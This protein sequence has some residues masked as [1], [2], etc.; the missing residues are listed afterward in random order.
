[1]DIRIRQCVLQLHAQVRARQRAGADKSAAT[2]APQHEPTW[3][4]AVAR[5]AARNKDTNAKVRA[6]ACR[7]GMAYW[8]TCNLRCAAG[9]R[10]DT[11]PS[12]L[13]R[14]SCLQHFSH[15][16]QSPGQVVGT[17][18]RIDIPV[19]PQLLQYEFVLFTGGQG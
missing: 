5:E 3:R 17:F 9:N 8:E 10:C 18:Q 12:A 7:K 15:L 2:P 13:L 1:M 4:D 11:A 14:G 16:Y 19:L 6:A